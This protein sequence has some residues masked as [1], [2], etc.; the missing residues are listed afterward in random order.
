MLQSIS[1]LVT[2]ICFALMPPAVRMNPHWLFMTSTPSERKPFTPRRRVVLPARVRRRV[3]TT[4]NEILVSY[5]LPDVME[6][7]LDSYYLN[8]EME[9][10]S[11][12]Y[13]LKE[14]MEQNLD[15]YYQQKELE[16]PIRT[17]PFPEV[18]KQ[19]L[20][21]YSL[22]KDSTNTDHLQQVLENNLLFYHLED[23][24]VHNI[25]C[26]SYSFTPTSPP[27]AT[28][29]RKPSESPRTRKPSK[30][31]AIP[32][33]TLSPTASTTMPTISPMVQPTPLP[34]QS[35]THRMMTLKPSKKTKR[36]S[37]STP[38]TPTPVI[39]IPPNVQPTAVP[40]QSSTER[41]SLKPS[42]KTKSPSTKTP[43]TNTPVI[44]T[45]SPTTSTQP[46]ISTYQEPTPTPSLPPTYHKTAKPSRRTKKPSTN[47]PVVPV[48]SP[49]ANNS[50]VP[51]TKPSKSTSPPTSTQILSYS[52][53]NYT[54][55]LDFSKTCST[56]NITKGPG[57][58]ISDSYCTSSNILGG[59]DAT[60]DKVPTVVNSIL[61]LE[62]GLDLV[63]VHYKSTRNASLT[64]G[65]IFNFTS[66]GASP[67]YTAPLGGMQMRL[68]GKN[69]LGDAVAVSWIVT[70][71]N[72]CSVQ[73][74]FPGNTIGWVIF[75]SYI[76]IVPN[77]CLRKKYITFLIITLTN[78][79]L[80]NTGRSGP[81]NQ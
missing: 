56:N 55:R 28:A 45:L 19:N 68:E 50:K 54:W 60:V 11:Q 6:Q 62:L 79:F 9:N 36:P 39:T 58:G 46:S 44:T 5:P 76:C 31:N 10:P 30:Y 70:Y 20:D 32:V 73:V 40:S 59:Q 47:T 33:L 41:K 27:I 37:T 18:I 43:H 23:V 81:P 4:T 12:P 77:P 57:T 14:V 61:I 22:P 65:D 67:N 52:P 1:L 75:V 35:P 16:K 34:S 2:I 29:T 64:D 63:P 49:T 25:F 42:K 15:S 72:N 26:M 21:S 53:F 48:I 71:S 69:K 74:F 66:I 78:L 17:F 3:R 8:Q 13:H 38:L 24:L 80:I 51:V 7:N